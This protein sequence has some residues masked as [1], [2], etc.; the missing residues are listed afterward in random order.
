MVIYDSAEYG[1]ASKN[2]RGS[3]YIIEDVALSYLKNIKS[4]ILHHI[5][6]VLT[7]RVSD[8]KNG[9]DIISRMRP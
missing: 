4:D 6:V 9:V 5:F 7:R 3:S 1:Y 8:L 2:T